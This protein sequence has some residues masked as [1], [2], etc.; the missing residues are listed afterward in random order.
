MSD[1][2]GTDLL[3]VPGPPTM[4]AHDASALDLRLGAGNVDRALEGPMLQSG[5]HNLGQAL[6]LR[7]LTPRGTLAELGHAVYG[8][9]LH[10]LIGTNKNESNRALCKAFVLEVVSQEPRVQDKVVAFVFD[11]ASE[12]PS[13]LRFTVTVQPVDGSTPVTI[14]LGVEL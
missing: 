13:E 9:R 12:G 10:E 1:P 6:I 11:I 8:S 4:A 3:V 2:F 7:M 14:G 5:A